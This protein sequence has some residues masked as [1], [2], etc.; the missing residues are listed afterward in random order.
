[1]NKIQI[2]IILIFS[3]STIVWGQSPTDQSESSVKEKIEWKTLTEENYQIEYPGNWEFKDGEQMSAK[4]FLLSPLSSESDDFKENVNLI[5][6]DLTGYDLSLDQFVELSEGQIKTMM[7]DGKIHLSE[8]KT[9]NE[10]E[11]QK[12]IY[13]GKQ[14]IT[15]L[16]FEQLYFV[17]NNKAYVLTLTCKEQE[18]DHYQETGEKILNSF[19][20]K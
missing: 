15:N 1:M 4:F 7:T 18:F 19:E 2:V 11:Y 6:Q 14:G 16:K 12:I 3:I 10:Q 9:K 8:R 5:V 13:T 20:I 17:I